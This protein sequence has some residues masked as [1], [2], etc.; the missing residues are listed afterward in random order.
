M[1]H[2]G[3][4]EKYVKIV[5]D[6]YRDSQ[7]AVRSAVG[8]SMWFNVEVGLHQ[9]SA[10]SPFLF[11]MVMDRLTDD[12]R[13]EAPWNMMFADDIVIA[14][15]SREQAEEDLERW[16]FALERRGMKVSRSKAEY[17]CISDN[18]TEETVQ[19][20]G[21]D[22]AKVQ[23]FKS[24]GC[25]VQDNGDCQKEVKK[26]IQ[27]GWNGWRKINGIMCDRKL[28]AKVKGR[29]YKVAVRPALMFG[30]ETTALPKGK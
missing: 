10:P 30:L 7:T 8:T 11:A 24:L 9:G 13:R 29:I 3:I 20:Q 25:T 17:L 6:M 5:K 12:V 14:S 23:D 21:A 4:Q 1:R 26:R 28:S 2:S 27:A 16:R 18:V 15:E 19:L 22:L